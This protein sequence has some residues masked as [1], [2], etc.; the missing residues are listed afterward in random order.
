[1]NSEFLMEA[2]GCISEQYILKY[3][4]IERKVKKQ[5]WKYTL[6][7]VACLAIAVF[8]VPNILKHNA[9]DREY[10]ARHKSFSSISEAEQ[11]YGNRLLFSR[12]E[13]YKEEKTIIQV[14]YTDKES[15]DNPLLWSDMHIMIGDYNDE[16]MITMSIFSSIY[17]GNYPNRLSDEVKILEIGDT[18]VS[19]EIYKVGSGFD[20]KNAV[21]AYF[22]YAGNYY[23]FLYRT[24]EEY[25]D[26]AFELLTQ[27]LVE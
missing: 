5:W 20:D 14:G 23:E 1:M 25:P 16:E 18:I 4:N 10:E 26:K 15:V 19:Y 6:P 8:I 13:E 7:L 11:E 3:E 27:M 24:A 2:I 12:L 17:T 21:V 22:T 9:P